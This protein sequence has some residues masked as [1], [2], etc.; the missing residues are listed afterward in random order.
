MF[1]NLKNNIC[2]FIILA[3]IILVLDMVFS[4]NLTFKQNNIDRR[5]GMNSMIDAE[6]ENSI[7][8]L[9]IGDSE[10]YT[11][12]SPLQFWKDYGI[13]SYSAGMAGMKLSESKDVLENAF[14][15]QQPKVVV[16]E[17]NSLYRADSSKSQANN[18][19]SKTLYR[20]FPALKNHNLWMRPF[21]SVR[22]D[23]YKGFE[24]NDVSKPSFTTNYMSKTDKIESIAADNI[25]LLNNIKEICEEHNAKLLLYSAPS[26]KNYN[27]S[28]HNAIAKL[29]EENNIKYVD[30]NLENEKL[31]INWDTDT[32]D[33]G[34]HLNSSGAVKTTAFL[35]EYLN[36]NYEL[37]DKRNTEIAKEWNELLADY[38]KYSN[39]AIA[40]IRGTEYL[41]A[42]IKR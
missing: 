1:S 21:Q 39:E 18:V 27:Y 29:A 14:L 16:L 41:I 38:E 12:F 15:N 2:F 36:T 33:Y 24:I 30:M 23:S 13:T 28:K 34:D 9:I 42:S 11:T 32:R 6:K 4:P 20:L 5:S 35:G 19:V 22:K 40:K 31:G 26:T 7:D 25:E 10:S 37:P 8:V 17:T 3:I